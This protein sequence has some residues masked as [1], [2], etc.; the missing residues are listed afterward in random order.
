MPEQIAVSLWADDNA[1]SMLDTILPTYEEVYAEPP[2]NEGPQDIADFIDRFRI[3][4][5]RP[6]FRLAT[7]RQAE[8]VIGFTFGF[9][10]PPDT[11]WWRGLLDPKPETFTHENGHRTFA[12][13]E[14]AV[15]AAWRRHGI[16]RRLHTL[17]LDG[18]T[19]ERVTLTMRPEPEAAPAQAAYASWGYKKLGRT[20]PWDGAPF[21]DAMLLEQS[22]SQVRRSA[23]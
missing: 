1:T 4:T 9:L 8:E 2:Y 7:A 10:L 12:I 15:R 16:A 5:K 3:Q 18:L 6:G 13:I 14:L 11:R 21:Y 22:N 23:E 17:L 19:A 20:R